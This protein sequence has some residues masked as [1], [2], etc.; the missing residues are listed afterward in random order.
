[1]EKKTFREKY[2]KKILV[3]VILFVGLIVYTIG[4]REGK[5]RKGNVLTTE[6]SFFDRNAKEIG[7]GFK[8]YVEEDDDRLTVKNIE[9]KK[10]EIH[11]TIELQENLEYNELEYILTEDKI[12]GIYK[13]DFECS[14][15]K[16]KQLIVNGKFDLK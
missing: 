7:E 6:S 12:Q 1:M 13:A 16:Y 4:F 3:I 11:V 10:G 2:G 5:M 15:D 8:K 9:Y 14:E